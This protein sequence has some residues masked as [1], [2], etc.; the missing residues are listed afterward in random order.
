MIMIHKSLWWYLWL[1]FVC[2]FSIL[3][4]LIQRPETGM[5]TR[6]SLGITIVEPFSNRIQNRKAHPSSQRHMKFP[7]KQQ[8]QRIKALF[9]GKIKIK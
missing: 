7:V 5:Y 9:S 4:S 6:T 8:S 2:E 1:C 3:E